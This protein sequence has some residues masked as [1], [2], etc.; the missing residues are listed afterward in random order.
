MSSRQRES[1]RIKSN[2]M[3]CARTSST[4]T[5][6]EERWLYIYAVAITQRD[7]TVVPRR[8]SS[9]NAASPRA[10]TKTTTTPTTPSTR[11]TPYDPPKPLFNQHTRPSHVS[12][13][14]PPIIG[15]SEN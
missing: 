5:D 6:D 1:N 8:P 15:H 3:R 12:K 9:T 2:Q 11:T 4:H 7:A 14:P 10:A 13:N